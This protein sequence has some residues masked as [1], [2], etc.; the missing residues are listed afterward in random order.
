VNFLHCGHDDDVVSTVKKSSLG[1]TTVVSAVKKF[2]LAD[3]T[4]V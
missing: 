4:V 3:M 1:G 2:D